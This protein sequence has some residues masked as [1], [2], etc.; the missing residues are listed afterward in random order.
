MNIEDN[1]IYLTDENGEEFP[2][3]LLDT[4]EFEDNEY[5]VLMTL[6][7]ADDEEESDIVILKMESVQGCEVSLVSLDN[8]SLFDRVFD[9]FVQKH[10]DEFDYSEN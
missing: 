2:F 9:I 8:D 5:A 10:P 6:D 1:I 7:C 4:I 3:E